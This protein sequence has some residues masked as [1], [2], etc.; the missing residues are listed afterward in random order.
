M[1]ISQRRTL[2]L[3]SAVFAASLTLTAFS[4]PQPQPVPAPTEP[5]VVLPRSTP[6]DGKPQIN[7]PRVASSNTGHLFLF[8]IPASGDAPL[9]YSVDSLPAGLQVDA[10]TGSITGSVKTPVSVAVTVHVKNA[11][12]EASRPLVIV[13]GDHKLALTPPLGWNSW[14]CWGLSVTDARVRAAADGFFN[15]GLVAHGFSYVNID[16][17]WEIQVPRAPRGG[18]ATAGAPTRD[19][20]GA[21]ITNTKFPNMKALGEYIHSKGLKFGIYSSP[22][23]TTCGGYAASWQ[24]EEQDA[25]T[26][27][28]WGV[29]Y[30]KYDWCSYNTV[31]P[32]DPNGGQRFSNFTL[33]QLKL[34]Y[35]VL[36]TALDKQDRDIVMSLCQYGMGNVWEWGAENGINGNCWRATGDINDSWQSMSRIG[37]AQNGHD[38]YAGPGHWNDTDMLVVG[39]VGW[40]NNPHDSKL[41]QNEQI[42]HISLWSILAAP[43]LLG[44]DLTRLDEFTNALMSNDEVLAVNQD[45]LGH[46]GKRISS[47]ALDDTETG[48]ANGRAH[49]VWAR[50]LWDG[51]VAVGLFNLD[52][53]PSKVTVSLKE[54]NDALKLNLAAGQPVRDLWQLKNLDP[55]KDAVTLEVPRHG[56]VLL[57]IGNGKSEAQCIDALVKANLPKPQ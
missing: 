55:A 38:A 50:E 39:K 1:F 44:C 26:W 18:G 29:D 17:G 40:G 57:K 36:R 16:D 11:K 7:G 5:A 8:K 53:A 35:Q 32:A 23:P 20:D 19:A 54:L 28:S 42:T 37:F 49:Q 21:I 24:H 34:P 13:V 47:K 12:G 52:N 41:T 46:Q 14:N 9:A 48:N 27:A 10:G 33:K 56:C 43:M 45:P 25:K 30:I 4:Q 31:V 51:T 22:G 6:A 15:S 3:A 2:I